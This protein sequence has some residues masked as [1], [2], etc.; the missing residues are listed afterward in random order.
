MHF[1]ISVAI[2]FFFNQSINQWSH[3]MAIDIKEESVSA[4]DPLSMENMENDVRWVD[5]DME[6]E[7]AMEHL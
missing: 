5:M 6:M 7:M 1:L 4:M 3:E 2:L